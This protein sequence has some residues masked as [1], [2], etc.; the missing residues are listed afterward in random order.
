MDDRDAVGLGDGFCARGIAGGDGN[1]IETGLLIS[2]EMAIVD[3]K[4]APENADAKIAFALAGEDKY[5]NPY[6]RSPASA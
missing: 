2:N 6:K 5:S 3:D 1:G 4:T